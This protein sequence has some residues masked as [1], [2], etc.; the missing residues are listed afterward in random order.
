MKVMIA[1]A[2]ALSV[3]SLAPEARGEEVCKAERLT[4]AALSLA[5]VYAKAETKAKAWKPDA[6]PTRITNTILGPLDEKGR[7]E[8]WNVTFYSKAANANVS[9]SA[10]RG[11]LSCYADAGAPG[12]I[13]DLKPGFFR[14][15]ARLYA[16]AK[17]HGASEIAQGFGVSVGTA[18]APSTNHATWYINFSKPDGKSAKLSIIVDA[19]TGAIEKVLKD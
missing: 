4:P 9:I 16:F 1:L 2:A 13:P 12:R 7:S 3:L 5:D 6:V 15:G 17:Q 10:F 11:S 8:A 14:D 19:N 18:A